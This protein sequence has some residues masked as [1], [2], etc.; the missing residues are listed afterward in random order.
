MICRMIKQ[1]IEKAKAARRRGTLAGKCCPMFQL[2]RRKGLGVSTVACSWARMRKKLYTFSNV[3]TRWV[4]RY[5][6]RRNVKPIK[7]TVDHNALTIS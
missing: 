3:I 5:D 2:L 6:N 1:D 7:V 4:S